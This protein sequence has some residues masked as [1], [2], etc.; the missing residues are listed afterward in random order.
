M[1][2]WI[3]LTLIISSVLI[4]FFLIGMFG[5]YFWVS[6]KWKDFYSEKEMKDY[7]IQINNSSKLPDNFYRA[8]DFMYPNQRD[9][10]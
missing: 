9:K 8:Y 6:T 1:K 7:A 2:R 4:G 10:N 5:L 3:K